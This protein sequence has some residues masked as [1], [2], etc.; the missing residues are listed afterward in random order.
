MEI[1]EAGQ[2]GEENAVFTVVIAGHRIEL[3]WVE[4]ASLREGGV[5]VLEA[6]STGSGTAAATWVR[7]WDQAT[8]GL[9]L[10]EAAASGRG[11]R[12]REPDAPEA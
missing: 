11:R 2:S 1:L 9:P 5:L 4:F 8:W 3:P 6:E 7:T 12:I 10:G